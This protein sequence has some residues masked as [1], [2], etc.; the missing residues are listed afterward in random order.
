M[1]T[2]SRQ[3]VARKPRPDDA[4]TAKD[5]RDVD[6]K[7]RAIAGALAVVALD[8]ATQVAEDEGAGRDDEKAEE[9]DPVG[10][11]AAEYGAGHEVEE[12]ENDDLLVVRGAPTRGE[13]HDLEQGR[14]LDRDVQGRAPGE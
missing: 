14:E 4:A 10:E 7:S 8:L 13:A 9:A 1:G 6:R 12:S 3:V 2:E 5:A 11:A